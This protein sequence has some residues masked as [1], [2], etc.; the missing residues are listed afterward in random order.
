V[1]LP[2]LEGLILKDC[3]FID[4][5]QKDVQFAMRRTIN[6]VNTSFRAVDLIGKQMFKSPWG[7]SFDDTQDVLFIKVSELKDHTNWKCDTAAAVNKY[8]KSDIDEY[9]MTLQ[10]SNTQAL[11]LRYKSIELLNVDRSGHRK[12]LKCH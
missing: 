11:W 7:Y 4:L 3:K 1:R 10:G 2:C 8:T 9:E 6:M 5:N 12:Y